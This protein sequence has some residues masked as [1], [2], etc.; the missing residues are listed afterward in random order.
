MTRSAPSFPAPLPAAEQTALCLRAKNGDVAAQ[1][2][3]I[4][5]NLRFLY[6]YARRFAAQTHL[7][8]IDDL[9]SEGVL[10]MLRAIEK[11]DPERGERFLTYATYWVCHDMRQAVVQTAIRISAPV[12]ILTRVWANRFARDRQALIERGTV[13]VEAALAKA[14]DMTPARLLASESLRQ[15]PTSMDQML[16]DES[17]R[18]MHDVLPDQEPLAEQRLSEESWSAQVQTFVALMGSKMRFTRRVVLAERII[19]GRP[20][21]EVGDMLGL[22]RERIR[23]IEMVLLQELRDALRAEFPEELGTKSE[24]TGKR[25]LRNF[26]RFVR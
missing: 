12:D 11:F 21:F 26:T 20:L 23:Q 1:H 15:P 24:P 13:D 5:T 2:L 19:A 10:G 16:G 22:S 9:M 14:S 18:S 4:R 8:D 3:L 6:K 7:L 25:G 17:A